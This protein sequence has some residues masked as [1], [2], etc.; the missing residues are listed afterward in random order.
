ME[1]NEM[2]KIWDVQNGRALYAIDEQALHNGV[3]A[4]KNKASKTAE[5]MEKILIFSLLTASGLI[6]WAIFKKGSFHTLQ[7]LLASLFVVAAAA[8]F[9]S[10]L[11]RLAWQNSFEKSMLGDLEQGIANASYQVALS[12]AAGLMYL[13]VA[14][15]SIISIYQRGMEWWKTILVVLFFIGGYF[16]SKWEHKKFYAYQK[17]NLMEMKAKLLSFEDDELQKL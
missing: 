12:K 16:A 4:K 1:F 17:Q 11:R 2:R 6:W 5:R 13:L 8:I 15:I 9:V 7:L 14:S 10:R 3:I